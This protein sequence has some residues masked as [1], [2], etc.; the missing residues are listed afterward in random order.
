[1]RPG[2]ASRLLHNSERGRRGSGRG[3]CLQ[4]ASRRRRRA[5]SGR[6]S[7]R[8]P[9]LHGPRSPDPGGER[10]ATSSAGAAARADGFTAAPYQ[11]QPLSRSV[12]RYWRRQL[13][14]APAPALLPRRAGDNPGLLSPPAA[15]RLPPVGR[16]CAPP[17]ETAPSVV[18]ERAATRYKRLAPRN[19]VQARRG[20]ARRG[21]ACGRGRRQAPPTASRHAARPA[22]RKTRRRRYL[23]AVPRSPQPRCPVATVEKAA[24]TVIASSSIGWLQGAS[25]AR[26]R[27]TQ[28][29]TF[30]Q[31]VPEIH[32]CENSLLLA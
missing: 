3:R 23:A 11:P 4:T 13:R 20:A 29:A 22:A 31:Q 26:A 6:R 30:Q 8:A 5:E 32:S 24:A 27:T 14:A 12:P 25:S 7:M 15:F 28:A 21:A 10:G 18:A 16:V 17:T 9:V 19:P 1:M 2:A